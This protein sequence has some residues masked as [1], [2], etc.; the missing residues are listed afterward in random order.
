MSINEVIE[1]LV[2]AI[3]NLHLSIRWI[4][5]AFGV[6]AAFDFA[7]AYIIITRLLGASG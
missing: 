7:V 1:G 6:Q 3:K 4:V 5:F 2:K